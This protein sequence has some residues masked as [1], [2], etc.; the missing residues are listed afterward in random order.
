MSCGCKG[1]KSEPVKIN[2]GGVINTSQH[3][4]IPLPKIED[5]TRVKDYL[6]AKVKTEE[7]RQFFA[8][9]ILNNFGE[10]LGS[11]CDHVCMERQVKRIHELEL[12]LLS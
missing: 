5:V 4:E 11:Y 2:K 12:K 1:Q 6:R 8:Q 3:V 10:V 7:E 9:F